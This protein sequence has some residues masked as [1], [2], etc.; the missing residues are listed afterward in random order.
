MLVLLTPILESLLIPRKDKYSI[1]PDI[2]RKLDYIGTEIY[3]EKPPID[4]L[5]LGPSSLWSSINASTVEKHLRKVNENEQIF[6]EN[7]GHTFNGIGL[8][9]FLLKDLIENRGVKTIFLGMVPIRQ[10]EVHRYIRYIWDPIQDSGDLNVKIFSRYYAE[11]ILESVPNLIRHKFFP[12]EVNPRILK[13]IDLTN[14]SLSQQRDFL[15]GTEKIKYE[16]LSRKHLEVSLKDILYDS[17]SSDIQALADYTEYQE[18]FIRKIMSLA[19]EKG[20]NI[21]LLLPPTLVQEAGFNK[22]QVLTYK[23]GERIPGKYLGIPMAKL[24]AGEDLQSIKK[25]YYDLLHTNR[26]G[27]EYFTKTM[28]KP[29]QEIYEQTN[30]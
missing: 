9:Y 3:S 6:V 4:F 19:K 14:G 18:F 29:L 21:Y 24:F 1:H 25:Y 2:L 28:L 27:S 13:F 20:I 22:L 12:P 8:D 15:N 17:T 11:K 5:F 16:E 26:N 7:F 10:T 23:N 30:H